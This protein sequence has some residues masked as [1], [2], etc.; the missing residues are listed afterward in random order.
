LLRAFGR[1][2]HRVAP[3]RSASRSTALRIPRPR[4]PHPAPSRSPPR[5]LGLRIALQ[6]A[7]HPAPSRSAS[8]D[9]IP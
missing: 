5:A 3:Q 2:L 9:G 7:P 8:L 6:R 4:A 1:A